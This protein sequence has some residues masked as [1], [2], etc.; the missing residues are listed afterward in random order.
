[1]LYLDNRSNKQSI[2]QIVTPD[3]IQENLIFSQD[4]IESSDQMNIDASSITLTQTGNYIDSVCVIRI[5]CI[6]GISSDVFIKTHD[7]QNILRN[8]K[9]CKYS[10]SSESFCQCQNIANYKCSH[11]PFSYCL[12]HGL[13]HQQD[14]KDEIHYLL[15]EAQ[16]NYCHMMKDQVFSLALLCNLK[17]R[18][19]MIFIPEVSEYGL[20]RVRVL[21][22]RVRVRVPTF[23][24]RVRV[25]PVL[26]LKYEF[27]K[28]LLRKI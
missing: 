20:F 2:E 3:S 18:N 8:I 26:R 28:R 14:L 27:L 7:K 12:Q 13:Q 10:I 19:I 22:Y 16:V 24:V 15:G 9:R 25:Q 1:M 23:R 17:K 5:E 21:T 4:C 6:S 11:C